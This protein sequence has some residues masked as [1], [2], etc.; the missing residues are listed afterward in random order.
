MDGAGM[1]SHRRWK[2]MSAVENLWQHALARKRQGQ[3]IRRVH[4]IST[5]TEK[6]FSMMHCSMQGDVLRSIN[7]SQ[8]IA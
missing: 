2:A 3:E 1:S 5:A 8:H 7:H 4:H 6:R